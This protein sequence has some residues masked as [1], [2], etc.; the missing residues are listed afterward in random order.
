M[1]PKSLQNKQADYDCARW[2]K[3][4]RYSEFAFKMEAILTLN[5]PIF[6]F[7]MKILNECHGFRSN[8]W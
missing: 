2:A 5:D 8:L 3:I 6:E 4:V 7:K 1:K